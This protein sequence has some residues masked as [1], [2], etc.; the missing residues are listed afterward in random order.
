MNA[1]NAY[2][3][4]TEKNQGNEQPLFFADDS[5]IDEFIEE[6]FPRSKCEE[7]SAVPTR[8]I[9]RNMGRKTAPIARGNRESG[10]IDLTALIAENRT[11]FPVE[12]TY[13]PEQID[14]IVVSHF[15]D[16]GIELESYNPEAQKENG[17][18]RIYS[19]INVTPGPKMFS[20]HFV[21]ATTRADPHILLDEGHIQRDVSRKTERVPK[22]YSIDEIPMNNG[23]VLPIINMELIEGI[24]AEQFLKSTP[25][26]KM[27]EKL[28]LFKEMVAAINDVHTAGYIHKDVKPKN[29][30][31]ELSEDNKRLAKLYVTDFGLASKIGAPLKTTS[32]NGTPEYMSPEHVMNT[33]TGGDP[34]MDIYSLGCVLYEMLTGEVPY[35]H[36][37]AKT[38]E[39]KSDEISADSIDREFP[40]KLYRAMVREEYRQ[41]PAY[42]K[43]MQG[44]SIKL[45]SIVAKCLKER[46]EQRYSSCEEVLYDLEGAIA[47][48]ILLDHLDEGVSKD[49][50]YTAE[51]TIDER[52]KMVSEYSAETAD[53][54]EEKLT[55]SYARNSA[56]RE[57]RPTV[58]SRPVRQSPDARGVTISYGTPRTAT[59]KVL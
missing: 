32:I 12:N 10:I 21:K 28:I 38:R 43:G 56:R 55:T 29:F 46:P 31:V 39:K 8:K 18:A 44:L 53:D 14:M 6:V 51:Q 4:E 13:T 25:E 52:A 27:Y 15:H 30:M 57:N 58:P 11:V 23:R 7:T 9:T 3:M 24:N 54:P 16:R 2:K 45:S 1:T 41:A 47:E 22:V 17:A 35:N 50:I 36:V 19:G 5:D 20:E 26:M 34:R 48:Q 33:E 42:K 40:I 59:K 37:V 49:G